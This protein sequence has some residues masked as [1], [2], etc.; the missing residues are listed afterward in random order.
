[1]YDESILRELRLALSNSLNLEDSNPATNYSPEDLYFE[2]MEKTKA[3]VKFLIDHNIERLKWVL[4]R[5]DVDES[6]LMR[7]LDS[8]SE[9]EATSIIAKMI[10]DRQVQKI[11]TRNAHRDSNPSDGLKEI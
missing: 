5:I 2:L 4:Y 6:K 7:A 10:I 9:T 11:K 1:M 3:A 8:M